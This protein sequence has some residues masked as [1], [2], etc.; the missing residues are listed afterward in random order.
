MAMTHTFS[1]TNTTAS[2]K[3]IALTKLGL[4][5]NYSKLQDSAGLCILDNKTTDIDQGEQIKITADKQ[6]VSTVLTNQHPNA[7]VTGARV[8]IRLDELLKTADD[9]TFRV[10]DPIIATLSLKAPDTSNISIAD[11]EKVLGRLVSVLY[12][13][14]GICRLSDLIRLATEPVAD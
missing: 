2:T 5:T 1:F 13:D 14:N 12:T 4:H 6:T 10:D 7:C 9:T 3:S 11:L 8:S